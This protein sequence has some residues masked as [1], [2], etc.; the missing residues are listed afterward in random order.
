[1]SQKDDRH[2][3]IIALSNAFWAVLV[4]TAVNLFC[5]WGVDWVRAWTGDAPIR[6]APTWIGSFIVAGT[7][8]WPAISIAALCGLL[9]RRMTGL[10]PTLI[11]VY[12]LALI[13]ARAALVVGIVLAV[14]HQNCENVN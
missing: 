1:M 6:K 9:G 8:G 14:M 10:T 2:P 7:T 5:G 13:D 4:C 12:L 11:A 3:A